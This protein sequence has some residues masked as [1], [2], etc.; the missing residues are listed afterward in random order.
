MVL[1][2]LAFQGRSKRKKELPPEAYVYEDG[3]SLSGAVR[4]LVEYFKSAEKKLT[5]NRGNKKGT[6]Q[7]Y[8]SAYLEFTRFNLSL[9]NMPELLDDQLAIFVASRVE[10]GD[11]SA[12]VESYLAGIKSMLSVDGIHVYQYLNC[13]VKSIDQSVQVQK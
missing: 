11:Y 13:E 5:A 3:S 7:T 4:L 12:T 2:N 6:Q 9:D 8:R 1:L 10:K